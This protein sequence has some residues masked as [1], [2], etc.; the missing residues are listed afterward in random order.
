MDTFTWPAA[1]SK[2][3]GKSLVCQPVGCDCAIGLNNL[4]LA[5]STNQ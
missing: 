4:Q 2:Q 3:L 5:G 1:D